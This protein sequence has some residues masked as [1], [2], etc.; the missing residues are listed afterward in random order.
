MSTQDFDVENP[1]IKGKTHGLPS[2]EM[3]ALSIECLESFLRKNEKEIY[4][5]GASLV[6]HATSEGGERGWSL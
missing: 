1:L 3:N 2:Q 5:L 4:L 6:L